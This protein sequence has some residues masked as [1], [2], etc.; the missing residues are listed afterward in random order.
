MKEEEGRKGNEMR[1]GRMV[2]REG[3]KKRGNDKRK[4]G[5]ETR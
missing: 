2:R 1:I 4:Q 5:K 3:N